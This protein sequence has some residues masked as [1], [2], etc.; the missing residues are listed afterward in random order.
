[1]GW[2]TNV[3]EA[4]YVY[5]KADARDVYDRIVKAIA[6]LAPEYDF[7]DKDDAGLKL[8]A[9]CTTFFCRFVDDIKIEISQQDGGVLM[10][11]RSASRVGKGDMFKNKKNILKIVRTANIGA[12][13]VTVYRE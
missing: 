11:T 13:K 4:D 5:E 12:F 1:M 6:Q 3:F 2:L 8:T 7:V 9:T 10:K